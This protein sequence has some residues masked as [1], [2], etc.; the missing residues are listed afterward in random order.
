MIIKPKIRGFICTTAHPVGCAKNVQNQIDYVSNK[1]ALINGPKKALIIGASTGYGLASRISAAFGSKAATVG[2]FYEKPAEG[3][4]TASSGWYNSVA[5]E[6]AAKKAGLYAKSING[7]AF[8]D[9]IKTKA[10]DAIKKD[11]GEVD[12]V[13]YSVASPRRV[14][15]K[16][17]QIFKS[18]L[19]PIKEAY[20]NKSI[21]MNSKKVIQV[22]IPVAS[23]EEVENTVS[24]MGGEDWNLWINALKEAGVLAPNALTIAYSY[25]GPEITQSI[26]RNGSIGAAKDH[27]ENTAKTLNSQLKGK[28]GR[29]LVSINKALVTQ[30]SS[31]IPVIPLYFALLLKVMK[32]KKVDENCIEQIHRLFS[33]MLYAGNSFEDVPVDDQGRVRI[34]DLELRADVQ[35]EA[36]GNWEIVNTENIKELA[37]LE[38]Y[39]D[40]F[41]RLFGFGIDGV[42][43]ESDVEHDLALG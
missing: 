11:L 29:A 27:L 42:D 17:G 33:Q 8:S 23:A 10:I 18:T 30:S 14:H 16:T 35:K 38:S 1:D 26:Y 5:F 32:E 25:M 41:L 31:A 4:R 43:Y 19:K 9:E 2:V 28:G 34:D 20:T 12:L 3:K 37:D 7:D 39:N 36:M 40:D 22:T 6:Q 24:V 21:D 13:V 15:P